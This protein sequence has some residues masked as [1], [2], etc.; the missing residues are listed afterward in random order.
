M[1][2]SKNKNEK[3]EGRWVFSNNSC[4][5]FS[6]W[7]C[8]MRECGIWKGCVWFLLI[9]FHVTNEF[10]CR[11]RRG[12]RQL[13]TLLSPSKRDANG[14]ERER[15]QALPLQDRDRKT[16]RVRERVS[17]RRFHGNLSGVCLVPGDGE[18][19]RGGER[20]EAR[21]KLSLVKGE[22]G[23]GK[24][25]MEQKSGTHLSI[26]SPPPIVCFSSPP[27]M[28]SPS[29]HLLC[30]LEGRKLAGL[31]SCEGGY[32]QC[33]TCLNP[34]SRTWRRRVAPRSVAALARLSA[35]LPL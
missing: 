26:S 13:P 25:I 4:N 30:S 12:F 3:K 17:V 18:E 11:Y 6:L 32:Y 33:F 7:P 24:E 21:R 1:H 23:M 31:A 5:Y 10:R 2:F 9:S 14:G 20:W 29:R 28:L 15:I 8:C 16:E 22:R 35:Y 34:R 19:R 27:V